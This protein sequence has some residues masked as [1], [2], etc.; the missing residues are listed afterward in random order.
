[1]MVFHVR[2][3]VSQGADLLRQGLV[4]GADAEVSG[5]ELVD[6]HVAHHTQAVGLRRV[7]RQL[8]AQAPQL[9]IGL[10]H[11]VL[12]ILG[13]SH[14]LTGQ[15]EELPVAGPETLFELDGGHAATF[16]RRSW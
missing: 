14:Q 1:M 3:V 11:H 13:A 4:V 12:S 6:T 7:L 2:P 16:I 8:V 9:Q 15:C 5:P 10:L